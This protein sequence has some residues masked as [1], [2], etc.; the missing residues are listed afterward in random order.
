MEPDINNLYNMKKKNTT[1]IGCKVC[2]NLKD[3]KLESGYTVNLEKG[4]KVTSIKTKPSKK[5]N[6]TVTL[7]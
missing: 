2:G 4:L 3:I 5:D 1:H 6:R 7:F